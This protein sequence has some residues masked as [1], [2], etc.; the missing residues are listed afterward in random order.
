MSTRM[1][2]R[3]Q[4]SPSLTSIESLL[5]A[6]AA[7]E[8]G[9]GPA[10]WPAVAKLLSK[11]PLLSRPKSFFSPQSC[12][13]M[14]ENLMKEAALEINVSNNAPHAAGN[15]RL[16]QKHYLARFQDL[17][18]LILAEESKFKTI[19]KEIEDIR[20]GFWDKDGQ[21]KAPTETT[22][23]LEASDQKADTSADQPMDDT[24]GGSD[25]SGVTE[26][27]ESSSPQTKDGPGPVDSSA[28]EIEPSAPTEMPDLDIETVQQASSPTPTAEFV[29]EPV[30]V[31]AEVEKL[32]EIV[33]ASNEPITPHDPLSQNAPDSETVKE[34]QDQKM[35][36]I[37]KTVEPEP[38]GIK[39]D[40]VEH[41]NQREEEEE[42]EEEIKDEEPKEEEEEGSQGRDE[43][44]N[45]EQDERTN[46][47]KALEHRDI[48]VMET[49]SEPVHPVADAAASANIE[50]T[51]DEGQSSGAEEPIAPRRRS[52]RH[53][54]SSAASVPP[55]AARTRLRNRVR[56]SESEPQNVDSDNDVDIENK[57]DTL[58][59]EDEVS[60]PFDAG[61][62]RRRDGKR[63]ASFMDAA[64][65]PQDK[66][67]LR[68][69]SEPADEEEPEP[70]LH[71]TRTR[72]TR[73]AMRTEEQ[74]ALKRFQNVIGMLHSQI[75]QHRNGTIFHNPIKNS[76]AP[77]YHEIVKRPMDLKTIKTRFK[78]GIIANSLEFQRDI[79][80][81]FANAMMYN[82][83]GSDVHAMAEDMMLESEGQINAFRQTEGRQLRHCDLK[84]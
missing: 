82:R 62:S 54:K 74:V 72:V 35:E 8:L 34:D 80:L 75:S 37:Q 19:L 40:D 46:S 79:Y 20:A 73:N 47:P 67:R 7:W 45:H 23:E 31:V 30:E 76:E 63:K 57:E 2:R 58:A 64:D 83:P 44:L 14:Y 84:V 59:I 69:D 13:S 50:P 26:S 66:K 77:D 3:P 68:E 78:D 33:E 9:A 16:A 65:S 15:L 38:S 53:R 49:E 56:V 12:H 60:S 4:Q 29:E 27:V 25:L 32:E 10:S 24:F 70:A 81:M 52:S 39:D 36:D 61:T 71:N 1:S 42:E 17:R 28:S 41:V 51:A 18:E 22:L 11:H 5:L 43:Q 6:Q 21:A 55:P 48:E